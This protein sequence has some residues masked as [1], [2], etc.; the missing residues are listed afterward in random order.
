MLEPAY[1]FETTPI[2][3]LP[4]EEGGTNTILTDLA[5]RVIDCYS[6]M[7]I[8]VIYQDA[9]GCLKAKNLR[10]KESDAKAGTESKK[11]WG[12]RAGLGSC[13]NLE[14]LPRRPFLR[15]SN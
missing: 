10:K 14:R 12:D 8:G 13:S 9:N 15:G 2:T 3:R 1:K 4:N 11:D 5:G 6:G 7:P